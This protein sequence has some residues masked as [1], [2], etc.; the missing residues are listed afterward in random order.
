MRI[1]RLLFTLCFIACF[2]QVEAQDAVLESIP[3]NGERE[4]ILIVLLLNGLIL[5]S[6]SR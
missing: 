3:I 2:M 5:M 4:S 6:N 1:N